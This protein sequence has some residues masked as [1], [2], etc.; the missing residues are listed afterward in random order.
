ML[1]IKFKNKPLNH[2]TGPSIIDTI[3]SL[4]AANEFFGFGSGILAVYID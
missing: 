4:K 1:K 3:D 2:V